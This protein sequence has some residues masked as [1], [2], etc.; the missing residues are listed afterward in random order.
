MY[1]N[2]PLVPATEDMVKGVSSS[3]E[4]EKPQA[5]KKRKLYKQ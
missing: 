2:K 5:S 1:S 4:T 3:T